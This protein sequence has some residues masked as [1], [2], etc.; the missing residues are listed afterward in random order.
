M[1]PSLLYVA[2]C[3]HKQLGPREYTIAR[4]SWNDKDPKFAKEG[5]NAKNYTF[6]DRD[7]KEQSVYSYFQAKY[8]VNLQFW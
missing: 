6:K 5:V 4:F 3:T 8:N 2:S 1:S 7:G